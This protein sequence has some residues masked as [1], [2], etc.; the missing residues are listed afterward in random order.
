[1]EVEVRP[2]EPSQEPA[3]PPGPPALEPIQD[4]T[5]LAL[6]CHPDGNKVALFPFVSILAE[7]HSLMK[8][9]NSSDAQSLGEPLQGEQFTIRDAF[10]YTDHRDTIMVFAVES[11]NQKGFVLASQVAPSCLLQLET[12]GSIR[13]LQAPTDCT[14]TDAGNFLCR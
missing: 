7:Y 1:M 13:D 14:I 9:G 3:A 12:T 4:K 11:T 6:V 10:R 2:Q 5:S 8:L